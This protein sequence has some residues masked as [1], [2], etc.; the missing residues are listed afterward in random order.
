VEGEGIL[1]K[2][3]QDVGLMRQAWLVGLTLKMSCLKIFTSMNTIKKN[4]FFIFMIIVS[5]IKLVIQEVF[6]NLIK[7][8]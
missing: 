5:R 3:L 6:G 4:L 7:T 8:I 2:M 1:F